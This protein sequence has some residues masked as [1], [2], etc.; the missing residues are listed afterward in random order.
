M[1]LTIK[2]MVEAA[3]E[4]IEKEKPIQLHWFEEIFCDFDQFKTFEKTE[5]VYEGKIDEHRWFGF[6]DIVFKL[7]IGDDVEYVKINIVTQ[8]YSEMQGIEDISSGY[9][10]FKIVHP[11]TVETIIYE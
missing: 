9:E 4:Y 5:I 1:K 7:K 10:K 3:N 6:Q 2:Q 8:S 11:K